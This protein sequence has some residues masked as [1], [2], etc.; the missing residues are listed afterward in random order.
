MGASGGG[1]PRRGPDRDGGA[2]ARSRVFTDPPGLVGAAGDGPEAGW[3]GP[4]REQGCD[5]AARS[6]TWP[7]FLSR[8]PRRGLEL[9][10]LPLLG[11]FDVPA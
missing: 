5:S 7:F 3:K 6:T 2:G 9:H 8:K 11:G 1:P 4:S 10:D